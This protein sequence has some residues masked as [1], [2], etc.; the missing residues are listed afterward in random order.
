MP[1]ISS[2]LFKLIDEK[3]KIYVT[4]LLGHDT[5]R[6]IERWQREGQVPDAKWKVVMVALKKEGILS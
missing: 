2:L 4:Q 3:G 6:I 1:D 5:T